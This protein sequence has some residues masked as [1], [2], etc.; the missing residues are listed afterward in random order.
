L[1]DIFRLENIIYYRLLHFIGICSQNIFQ[2]RNE[3]Y[4]FFLHHVMKEKS[5][6]QLFS[7]SRYVGKIERTT[8]SMR[9]AH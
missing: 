6:G 5:N 9:E 4:N 2:L 7:S 3:A 1:L 8:S